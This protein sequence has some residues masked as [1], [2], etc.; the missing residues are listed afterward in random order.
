MTQLDFL[1][2]LYQPRWLRLD[3]LP[4]RP[5]R[6]QPPLG[7]ATRWQAGSRWCGT[8]AGAQPRGRL[9]LLPT[10]QP[11]IEEQTWGRPAA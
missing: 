8:L 6:Q 10:A 9:T 1:P 3:A 5:T 2:I 4:P 7:R 11:Q